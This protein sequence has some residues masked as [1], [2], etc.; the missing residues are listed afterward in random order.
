[1]NEMDLLTRLRDEVPLSYPSPTA[2]RAFLAGLAGGTDGRRARR[3]R[4]RTLSF[5]ARTP[6][7]AGATALAVGLTAGIVVLALP[8]GGRPP[9]G[10]RGRSAVSASAS[11]PTGVSV[12]TSASLPTGTATAPLSAQLL[13]EVAANAVL[14]QPAV[15]PTQ[16]V[17]RKV[18]IS[19]WLPPRLAQIQHRSRRVFVENTW[20]MADGAHWYSPGPAQGVVG[21]DL[22]YSQIGSL[23]AN[24]VAL[25]AYLAHLDYPNPN[26]TTANKATA[27]F[28]NIEEM[29]TV[30]VLPPKLTAELYHALADIPTVIAE[31]NVKDTAGQAALAFI[32]PQNG[33]SMNQEIFLRPSDYRMLGDSVWLTGGPGVL[34]A[35]AVLTQAFVSGSGKLP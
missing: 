22:P 6:L 14:A 18:E 31:R 29:L 19:T 27:E 2:Q 1:M 9:A 11:L 34:H 33:Q 7:V 21:P 5:Y 3:A 12:P 24:P 25:D 8:S 32:L 10:A 20:E 35:E 15:K 4:R 28:S 23:P 30:W 13:A 17:Y 26:A 16:W